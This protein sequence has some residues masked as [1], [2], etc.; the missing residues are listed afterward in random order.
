MTLSGDGQD[1]LVIDS[2]G[3]VLSVT[4]SQASNNPG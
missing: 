4:T 1:D 3:R 2:G